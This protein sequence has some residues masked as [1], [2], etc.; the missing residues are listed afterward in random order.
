MFCNRFISSDAVSIIIN[1]R[2]VQTRVKTAM[3]THVHWQ[4]A[5]L[6]RLVF[7]IYVI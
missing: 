1:K 7:V 3:Q 2:S 4:A 5:D 6:Q